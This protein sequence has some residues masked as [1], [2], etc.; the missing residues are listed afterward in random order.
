MSSFIISEALDLLS[1]TDIPF[2][3]SGNEK[4]IIKC[5]NSIDSLSKNALSFFRRNDVDSYRKNFNQ[6]NLV[7]LK[8]EADINLPPGNFIF[9]EN[10]SLVFNIIGIL[11][12]EK[13]KVTIDP[14]ANIHDKSIIGK[15]TSVGAYCSIGSNVKIGDNCIIMDTCTI[16]NADIGNNTIIHS[17]TRIGNPG[18]GSY[19]DKKGKY[20][21]FPHFGKVIIGNRVV[22]QDN[23]VINQGT[24]NNTIIEEDTRIGPLTCIGHGV[25]IGKSCFVSQSVTIAGSVAIGNFV[26]IW[27]NASI[28]DGIL[29]GNGSTI[30]MG[31]VV[32]KN[33]P[34]NESWVGNPAKKM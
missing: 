19:L 13:A 11:L 7:V 3:F 31:A 15:S 24:L 26:K 27:G 4:V 22:I 18:L 21:D 17:G 6:T 12:K 8:P 14:T 32:V 34:E 10:P 1:K 29:V 16:N 9:V 5:A 20:H 23:T 33:I 28:R 30:G 25:R 2:R